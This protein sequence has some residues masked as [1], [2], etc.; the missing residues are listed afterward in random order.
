MF[1]WDEDNLEHIVKH[2]IEPEE[3]EEAILD[4][5]R[6][7]FPAHRGPKGEKRKGVI[8]RTET[9]RILVVIIEKVTRGFRV[10][11]ARDATSNEKRS[12]RK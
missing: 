8:G 10:I 7:P 6:R 9:G 12:Y 2:Q 11:T 3:A 4:P 5:N 1:E